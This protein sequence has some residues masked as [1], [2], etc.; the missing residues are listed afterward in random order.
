MTGVVLFLTSAELDATDSYEEA[1]YARTQ[2]T[3]ASGRTAFVYVDA[4]SLGG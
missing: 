2:V 4:S 1:A 3:L